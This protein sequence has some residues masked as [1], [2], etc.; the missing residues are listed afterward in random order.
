MYHRIFTLAFLLC[1]SVL[2]GRAQYANNWVMGD[3]ELNFH[4]DPPTI[5]RASALHQVV[6]MGIISD[7]NGNLLF[8]TDG[9]FV[10]N[11]SHQLMPNGTLLQYHGMN[12]YQKSMVVPKP[13]DANRFYIFTVDPASGQSVSGLF[14][15]EVD[16][17][18]AGGKG[19]VVVKNV[20]LIPNTSNDLTAVLHENGQDVWLVVHG[21]NN[22][23]YHVVRIT[24][25][26]IS[27]QI[28]EQQIGST[29]TFV[30]AQMKFSPDGTK[31]AVSSGGDIDLLDFN[32]ATATFSN[33][34]KLTF[35]DMESSPMISGLEFS[36]D[37]TKLYTSELRYYALLQF[38]LS[39]STTEA[40]QNSRTEVGNGVMYNNLAQFQLGLDGK[41]YVTKGGGGGGSDHLGVIVN[42]NADA[43]EVIW[44]ENGLYLDGGS[45]FVNATPNF[46]QNYFFKTS[47]SF[48]TRCQAAPIQ[49]RVSNTHRLNSVQWFFGE[50]STSTET[51]PQFT[52][53]Q[54]GTYLVT[55]VAKYDGRT[56]V[57]TRPIEVNPFT[58]FE[59]GNDATLCHGTKL[60]I[61]DNF[62]SYLWNTGDTT[63]W[64]RVDESGPYQLRVENNFGCYFTDA[65]NVT[66][67]PLPVTTLP[68]TIDLTVP[69]S[70]ELIPGTFQ[71]YSWSTGET[72][73][74]ILVQKEGWYSVA[75]EDSH[76]CASA[77]SVYVQDDII[78]LPEPPSRWIRLNPQPSG[79]TARDIFFLDERRGFIV[80]EAELLR[81]TNGGATW[82][83]QRKML[84][85][86]RITFKNNIGYTIGN[87]G[88]IYKSTHLG[89]GWN[90]LNIN[91]SDN[92]NAITLLD[93]D[94]VFVTSDNKLFFSFNGGKN[95][96]QRAVN[97]ANINID[98]SYF[99]SRLVGHAACQ[100]G[101]IIKTVDG[102]VSWRETY[103]ANVFPSNFF[104]ITFVN[105][106]IGYATREHTEVLKTTDGGETWTSISNPYS[107]GYDI[108]FIDHKTGFLAGEHGSIMKT[109]NGGFQ[110]QPMGNGG[111]IWANDLFAIQF[112]DENI[113]F[114]AG[115]RGRILK[116]LDGGN[117]WTEYSET[118]NLVQHLEFTSHE[119]GYMFSK[120]TLFKTTDGGFNWEP[121]DTDKAGKFD[122]INDQVGYVAY[123]GAIFKTTDG[124]QNWTKTHTQ[125][126]VAA[127]DEIYTMHFFN[128][129]FGYLTTSYGGA[130]K[131]IDGGKNWSG[132]GPGI[133]FGQIQFVTEQ[134]G[135][136]KNMGNYYDR[137]YKTTDGGANW[138]LIYE[139]TDDIDALHFVNESVGYFVGYPN[140]NYKTIDGGANWTKI[141]VPYEYYKDVKFLTKDLGY[142]MD[143]EGQ[144]FKTEDGGA[145]WSPELRV[146][147]L[148][149][150]Y[151]TQDDVFAAGDFGSVFK[152]TLYLE[153]LFHF[154]S[155]SVNDITETSATMIT[156]VTSSRNLQGVPLIAMIGTVP[157]VYTHQMQVEI[158]N[159]PVEKEVAYHFQQLEPG[160]LY[161]CKMKAVDGS[162]TVSTT[163]FAF[164]TTEAVTGVTPELNDA[165]RIY[166]NPTTGILRVD[167][168]NGAR[169]FSFAA[170]DMLGNELVAG[171]SDD[172][173]ADISAL[174][175]GLYLIRI[176]SGSGEK[177]IRIVKQ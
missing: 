28:T 79:A 175:P 70:V 78:D 141:N 45:S 112:I 75:V 172:G 21:I 132:M 177:L 16:M 174:R 53:T 77:Q 92:L 73:P 6:G 138:N 129:N 155:V 98:D 22:N 42:P 146:Y 103:V 15:S 143:E 17:T 90:K 117:N 57:I 31:I 39:F 64:V 108:Q 23:K 72:T 176:T 109:T 48:D 104:R 106:M 114:A 74:S 128:E 34:R 102:G 1:I 149:S 118:Y 44:E 145:T 76:G 133:S 3:Y 35:V 62:V 99:T 96:Q 68:D 47:F 5:T 30:S 147:G 52:Y 124:G 40:I 135:F 65:I 49:F 93:E 142:V 46:I 165:I 4:A 156:H 58:S 151:F 8:Y 14:Y 105:D 169:Q 116:T 163:D 167:I 161:F 113:G 120:E 126:Q 66:V 100:G 2:S 150:L 134:V 125:A 171:S 127:G 18:L 130:L 89:D 140:A 82:E 71:K 20:N 32:D 56:D 121:L 13:G 153:D 148:T 84:N 101:K 51:N 157:G 69:G 36:S 85:A 173:T 139:I 159:G 29:F 170:Y 115:M 95:W 137:I 164:S 166:P 107:A 59:L 33:A 158:L 91:T 111:L 87:S 43:D 41:I 136:A 24:A 160:T 12:G 26:G 37:G 86:K 67:N 83:V 27:A 97:L 119:V 55:L 144:V 63:R 154:G 50:G 9:F 11:N 7:P 152:T 88:T 123:Y 61:D 131:T 25:S 19:D 60:S 38:D 10:W 94:S 110:W 168:E 162:E 81:T 80:N 54:A 122:F